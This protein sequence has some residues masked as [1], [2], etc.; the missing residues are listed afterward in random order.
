MHWILLV[1]FTIGIIFSVSAGLATLAYILFILLIADLIG[2][3]ISKLFSGAAGVASGAL[4]IAEEEAQ[5]VAN[6]KTK[7][8]AGKKFLEEGIGKIGKELGKREKE[9]EEHK[10]M[11]SKLSLASA[12]GAVENFLSG[13]GK[14]FRK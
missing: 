4:E 11:K 14:L 9:K 5:E 8:P 12:V 2:G 10:K 7:H 13:F 6:A 3:F 1:L